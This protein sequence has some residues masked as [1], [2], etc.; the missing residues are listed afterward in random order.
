MIPSFDPVSQVQW[1]HV[2]PDQLADAPAHDFRT[3]PVLESEGLEGPHLCQQCGK[4]YART[5]DLNKHLKTHIRPF[6]CPVQE[7]R[8]HTFGWPTEKELDR[9][10]NDKHST[11]P[12]VVSCLWPNCDYTSKRE[13]NC[14][15]HMEKTHGWTYVRSRHGSKEEVPSKQLGNSSDLS[16]LP[17]YPRSNLT[18]RTVPGLALSPSP[19]EPCLSASYDS[20]TSGSL[21]SAIPYGA[22]VYIPWSSPV[23]RS[24]N[25]DNFMEDFT[26]VYAADTQIVNCDDEWLRVPVDPKLYSTTTLENHTLEQSS[27][28][29][30]T[31][32]RGELLKVLP[33]IV[34]PKTSPDMKTQVLTPLSEPSPVFMHQPYFEGQGAAPQDAEADSGRG[35]SAAW[36]L[37][38]GDIER[39]I[40]LG[41]RQVRVSKEPDD[42]SDG[43]EEPPR[44]R[45]KPPGGH[46]DDL[47][48]RKM[49]CPFRVA[50]PDIYEQSLDQRYFSCHTEHAN[51]STVVR[52]LGRPAH[53]LDVDNARQSIS[54]FN[55]AD[56]EH[57]HPRA[58]LCKKCWRAFSDAE[59]FEN[60]IIQAKCENVSRSKREKFDILLNT[61]CRID[62]SRRRHSPDDVS[63]AD[64]S[65]AS[66]GEAEDVSARSK[67]MGDGLV[68]RSEFLALS[69]RIEVLER[70]LSQQMPQA[71]P[72]ILPTRTDALVPSS[73]GTS[74]QPAQPF[75]HYSFDAGPG[76]SASRPAGTRNIGGTMGPGS[77]HYGNPAG[78]NQ[79]TGRVVPE[80]RSSGVRC[81]EDMSIAHR[82]N[83]VIA[84]QP[85]SHVGGDLVG[86]QGS[87][88][89]SLAYRS[90]PATRMPNVAAA[91]SAGVRN[92]G[93]AGVGAVGGGV[94]AAGVSS[95]SNPNVTRAQEAEYTQEGV[96]QESTNTTLRNRWYQAMDASEAVLETANFF[97]D[98]PMDDDI[99]R[100]LNMDT[101]IDD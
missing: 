94:V 69:A 98:G 67:A 62:S 13:S 50:N 45:S 35:T 20:P 37:R 73:L 58:G 29:Q 86:S 23:T 96:S 49:P 79:A 77:V 66:E 57:G 10:Y 95:G 39:L 12:R 72:R 88:T 11:E 42:D 28:P 16:Q 54:S 99:N 59:V 56:N 43:D 6:K 74:I 44:K 18:I 47:G 100:Y 2:V 89:G 97:D 70:A 60:H 51:I 87:S 90:T 1:G 46:D 4:S 25:H 34:T 15:Q 32:E 24:R 83:Q 71:T 84:H 22:D 48:D 55:V 9:H 41:K 36:G 30:A 61:F 31:P 7:C 38:S 92:G 78:F 91:V 64:T 19:L 26:Q 65:G 82:A 8:Y 68:R 21:G 85:D 14:K 81:P 17:T 101:Q 80:F 53:N 3:S 52:H 76:P 5:C 40:P 27:T 63:E 33:T 93:G 75:G